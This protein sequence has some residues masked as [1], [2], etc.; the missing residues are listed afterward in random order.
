MTMEKVDIQ[1]IYRLIQ[2]KALTPEQEQAL[3]GRASALGLQENDELFPLLVLMDAYSGILSALPKEMQQQANL[4]AKN[5]ENLATQNMSGLAEKVLE[6]ASGELKKTIESIA[7]VRDIKIDLLASVFDLLIGS[8]YVALGFIAGFSVAATPHSPFW[9][10]PGKNGFSFFLHAF[11]TIPLG[12]FFSFP[13][14]TV[15]FIWLYN[16]YKEKGKTKNGEKKLIFGIIL[17]FIAAVPA[18]ISF[19]FSN[20]FKG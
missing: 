15:S 10:K 4:V 16:G 20:I 3:L 11:M 2:G 7:E 6:K 14:F 5:A 13:M 17:F 12:F 8:C 9:F 18:I 1:E 19:H